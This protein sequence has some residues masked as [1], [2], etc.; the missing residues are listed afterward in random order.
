MGGNRRKERGMIWRDERFLARIKKITEKEFEGEGFEGI[1]W[2][3]F[4]KTSIF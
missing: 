4:V 1:E 2:M 3:I